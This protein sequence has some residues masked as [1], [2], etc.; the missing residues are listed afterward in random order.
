MKEPK[1]KLQ[2]DYLI[3]RKNALRTTSYKFYWGGIADFKV[4]AFNLAL[5]VPTGNRS[6]IPNK[7]YM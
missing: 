5:N 1:D 6:E 7:T 4:L 2:T 3:D